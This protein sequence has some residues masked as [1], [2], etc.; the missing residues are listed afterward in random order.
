VIPI[1]TA[2]DFVTKLRTGGNFLITNP[3]IGRLPRRFATIHPLGPI[4]LDGGASWVAIDSGSSNLDPGFEGSLFGTFVG[5]ITNINMETQIPLAHTFEGELTKSSLFIWVVDPT[6][7][8]SI[9]TGV[10]ANE[11]GAMFNFLRGP[12]LIEDNYIV[13]RPSGS[14]FGNLVAS[15][16]YRATGT[17][18]VLRHNRFLSMTGHPRRAGLIDQ[19]WT[20]V[21]LTIEGDTKFPLSN[22]YGPSG[23]H[24]CTGYGNRVMW[25]CGAAHDFGPDYGLVTASRSP[26]VIDGLTMNTS[27]MMGLIGHS[28]SNVTIR[29]SRLIRY[30]NDR[31]PN[32][33]HNPVVTCNR[34][35]CDGLIVTSSTPGSSVTIENVELMFPGNGS[36]PFWPIE[37]H[38]LIGGNFFNLTVDLTTIVTDNYMTISGGPIGTVSGTRSV[39]NS[40]LNGTPFF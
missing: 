23:I 25:Y 15:M 20:S 31:R 18:V 5:S 12:S 3:S 21:G 17:S 34:P 37:W 10:S 13:F 35:N 33:G 39:T 14:Y 8:Y 30:R 4:C 38:H 28:T 16:A 11:V 2:S 7:P 6:R 26:I 29:N 19:N 22:G 32:G 1:A 27:A 36:A 9:P 24:D 40:T